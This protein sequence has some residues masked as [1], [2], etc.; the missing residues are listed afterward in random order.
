MHCNLTARRCECSVGGASRDPAVSA[1]FCPALDTGESCALQ[2]VDAVAGGLLADRSN[3][4]FHDPGARMH[5]KIWSALGQ[6]EKKVNQPDSP[7]FL[8]RY[9]HLSQFTSFLAI[10]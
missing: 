9:S 3:P 8:G 7:D 10:Q 5:K 6:L 2:Q 4:G 1:L